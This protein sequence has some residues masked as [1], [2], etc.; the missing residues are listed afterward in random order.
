MLDE[1]CWM[2]STNVINFHPTFL[3]HLSN[4]L[5]KMLDRFNYALSKQFWTKHYKQILGIKQK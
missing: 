2:T 3:Q 4:I 5:D 1:P